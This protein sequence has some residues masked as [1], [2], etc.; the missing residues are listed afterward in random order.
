MLTIPKNALVPYT[1][2]TGP[3]MTSIRATSS[4][5]TGLSQPTPAN[6][7]HGSLIVAPSTST[8]IRVLKSPGTCSPRTPTRSV[9]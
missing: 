7:F 5:D 8:R 6:W 1:D 2:D 9:M 3:R 4:I